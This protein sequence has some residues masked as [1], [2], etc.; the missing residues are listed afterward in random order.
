MVEPKTK[1]N[2]SE[3]AG[4]GPNQCPLLILEQG[5]LARCAWLDIIIYKQVT[6]KCLLFPLFEWEHLL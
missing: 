6:M 5:G 2:H 1:E 4:L 3:R